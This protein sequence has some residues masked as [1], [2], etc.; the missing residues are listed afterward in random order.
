MTRPKSPSQSQKDDKLA[1]EAVTQVLGITNI[2]TIDDE[3]EALNEI[4]DTADS[5]DD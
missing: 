1:K 2:T 3:D 5:D 4:L